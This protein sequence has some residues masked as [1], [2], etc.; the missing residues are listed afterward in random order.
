MPGAYI[1]ETGAL[2]LSESRLDAEL[3]NLKGRNVELLISLVEDEELGC[4]AYEDVADHA[5]KLGIAIERCPIA[6]YRALSIRRGS[7]WSAMF[8]DATVLLQ[9]G[10]SVAFHC[11]AGI[12]RSG[13]MAG[14]LLVHLGMSPLTAVSTVRLAQPEALKTDGQVAYVQAYQPRLNRAG[15]VGGHFV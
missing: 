2:N 5:L 8:S 1:G 15:I 4:I 3:R 7:D 9:K 14:S 12:R 11:M 13:M 10:R 6:D